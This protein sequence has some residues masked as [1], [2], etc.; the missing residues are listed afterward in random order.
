MPCPRPASVTVST[1]PGFSFELVIP[2]QAAAPIPPDIAD[3]F[4]SNELLA[5]LRE[6]A[7]RSSTGTLIRHTTDLLRS[8]HP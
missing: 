3:L 5:D 6:L 7:W 8:G 1:A 2:K 4:I